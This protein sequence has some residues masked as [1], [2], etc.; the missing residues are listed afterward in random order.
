MN[1]GTAIVLFT[2]F[3]DF[4][5][6][7][8]RNPLEI[9]AFFLQMSVAGPLLG[10]ALGFAAYLWM[11]RASRRFSHSDITVQT[12]ITVCCAYLSF[13]MGESEAGVSGVLCVVAAALVLAKYAWPVVVSHDSLE[14]VWH[15]VEYF[16]N[17]LIFVLAGVISR[18]ALMSDT[19]RAVDYAYLFL[20]YLV[21]TAIRGAMIVLGYPALKR[22]GYGTTPKDAF[23]MVYGGL[24]GAVGLAL[25]ISVKSTLDDVDTG[26]RVVFF[27]SGL[28]FLTLIINGTTSGLLLRKLGLVGTPALKEQMIAKVR[29][30][31]V[32]HAEEEY[33]KACCEMNHDARDGLDLIANLR[34][35]SGSTKC[36]ETAAHVREMRRKKFGGSRDTAVESASFYDADEVTAVLNTLPPANVDQVAMMRETFL[37]MVRAGYW[38]MVEAGHLPTKGNATLELLKSVDVAI[39]DPSVPLADWA[40]LEPKADVSADTIMYDDFLECLDKVLPSSVTWDNELHYLLNFKTQETAYYICNAFIESHGN[41]QVKLATFFGDDP[42]ID[43]AEEAT[44]VLESLAVVARARAI[45]GKMSVAL[46]AHIKTMVVAEHL[47]ELQQTFVHHVVEQGVLSHADAETLEHELSHDRSNIE[48]ARKARAHALAKGA[49]KG[50]SSQINLRRPSALRHSQDEEEGDKRND[51]TSG[52]K[53]VMVKRGP[54]SNNYKVAPEEA[55]P[56]AGDAAAMM[57]DDTGAA[58]HAA[59]SEA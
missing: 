31:V 49:A 18:R 32:A 36:D 55:E 48:A 26:N 17:T 42:T 10:L 4:H 46:I 58:H 34:H 45:L 28:A 29:E 11:A 20:F 7:K 1:D 50:E 5:A 38:E 9:A 39:D 57:V 27:V 3:M 43:S 8:L 6:G 14:N 21:M 37:G 15:A 2:L 51:R 47:V 23:F 13:F 25:A 53:S 12:S 52:S 22:L 41:A 44:I 54:S 24:R 59:G 56:P 40:V 19:I 33:D 35:M 30:R 16:G